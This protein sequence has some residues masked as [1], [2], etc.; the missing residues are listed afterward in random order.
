[1]WMRGSRL[2]HTNM[3]LFINASLPTSS[4]AMKRVNVLFDRQIIK[5]SQDDITSE[6]EP[7]VIDLKGKILLP[8]AIDA[9]S[10]LL[11]AKKGF[12]TGFSKIGSSVW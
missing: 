12:A 9:H 4:A 2:W 8:G 1:M 7:Q 11:G 10:H 6:E 5:I 3:K